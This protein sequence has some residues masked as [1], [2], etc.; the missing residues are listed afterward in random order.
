MNFIVIDDDGDRFTE[1]QAETTEAAK[2]QLEGI[3][4][5]KQTS[6]RGLPRSLRSLKL[7]HVVGELAITET[8][9][10]PVAFNWD[11]KPVDK[12]NDQEEDEPED[13]D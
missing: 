11:P 9:P 12:N 7:C 1:F 5:K 6:F 13:D 10:P 2:A 3:V 8:A 4:I